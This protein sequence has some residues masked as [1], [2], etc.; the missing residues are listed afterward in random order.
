M[1]LNWVKD[2][3]WA[4]GGDPN[5]VGF[6]GLVRLTKRQVTL[7]GQSAGAGVTSML[8]LNES[9]DLFRSGVRQSIPNPTL[10]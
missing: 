8:Y 9:I 5:K 4:F 2:N 1:A 7:M 6:A 10:R 3:I